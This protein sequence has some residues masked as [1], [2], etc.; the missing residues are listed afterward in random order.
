MS[1]YTNHYAEKIFL[2]LSPLVGIVMT[3]TII[4]LQSSKMGINE[5]QLTRED[6]SLIAENIRKGLVT[7]LGSE[8]A[9]LVANKIANIV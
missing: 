3:K 4:H 7:F 5:E 8:S 1:T 6:M 2:I 9:N